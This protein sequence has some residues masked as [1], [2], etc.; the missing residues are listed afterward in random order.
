MP[1][2]AQVRGSCWVGERAP[3]GMATSHG[4]CCRSTLRM[5]ADGTLCTSAIPLVS[6]RDRKSMAPGLLAAADYAGRPVICLRGYHPEASACCWLR[7]GE[8]C[9]SLR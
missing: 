3:T 8:T 9:C 6:T 1:P 7:L 2:S 5:L 4:P